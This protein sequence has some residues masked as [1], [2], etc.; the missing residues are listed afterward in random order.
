MANEG[1]RMSNKCDICN[2]EIGTDVEAGQ[3]TQETVLCSECL[4]KI[5]REEKDNGTLCGLRT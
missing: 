1:I 5:V 4:D 2:K 3:T